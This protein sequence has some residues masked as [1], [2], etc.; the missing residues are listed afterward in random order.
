MSGLGQDLVDASLVHERDEPEAPAPRSPG[1]RGDA[2][3]R[4][5]VG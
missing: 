1:R 2:E 3:R 5:K 4:K